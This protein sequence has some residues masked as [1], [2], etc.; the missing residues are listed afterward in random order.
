[1]AKSTVLGSAILFLKGDDSHLEKVMGQAQ[2]KFGKSW[3]QM[4]YKMKAAVDSLEAELAPLR[5]EQLVAFK[6]TVVARGF[7]KAA[8]EA[9]TDAAAVR[10]HM[11]V[12]KVGKRYGTTRDD[13]TFVLDDTLVAAAVEGFMSSAPL[14]TAAKPTAFAEVPRINLPGRDEAPDNVTPIRSIPSAM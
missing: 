5:A 13:G 8:V 12:T 6:A 4:G 2:K 7:D 10:R 9:C 3:K 1:M 14:P 11:A